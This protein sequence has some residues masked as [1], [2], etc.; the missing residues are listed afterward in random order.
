MEG[1]KLAQIFTSYYT[2]WFPDYE[3]KI[4]LKLKYLI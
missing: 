4:M 3:H 2:R 1:S